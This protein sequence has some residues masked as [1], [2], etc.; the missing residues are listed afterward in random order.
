MCFKKK[1]PAFLLMLSLSFS[2]LVPSSLYA[3]GWIQSADGRWWYG[4]NEDNSEYYKD[5]WQII[6]DV[7]YYF[8]KDGWCLQNTLTPDG[9]T[10]D[11]NGAWVINGVVQKAASIAGSLYRGGGEADD[12]GRQIVNYARSFVDIL[13][14]VTA[15]SSLKTGTDCS[16]FV[17]EIF[18]QFGYDLPHSTLMQYR[19]T[20]PISREELRAGDLIYFSRTNDPGNLTHVGIFAGYDSNTGFDMFVHNTNHERGFVKYDSLYDMETWSQKAVAY[21]RV[22]NHD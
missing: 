7:Y 1:T 4:I 11:G 21:G 10:V 19:S 16:G 9:Y 3:A 13:P 15:G 17:C 22:I 2:S 20:Q 6:S 14:Y 12:P 5:G 18:R 8:D